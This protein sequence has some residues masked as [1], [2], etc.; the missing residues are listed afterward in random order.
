MQFDEFLIAL[1]A[2]ATELSEP[3]LR[4][5]LHLCATAIEEGSYSLAI[6]DRDIRSRLK[7]GGDS[8]DK[9]K[10]D[11]ERILRVEARPRQSTVYHIPSNWFPIA[12]NMFSTVCDP[13]NG[14]RPYL[15]AP[16]RAPVGGARVTPETGQRAPVG[17]AACPGRRGSVTPETGQRAPVG[18]AQT[19]ENSEKTMDMSIMDS[20]RSRSNS[21]SGLRKDS[22]ECI[23]RV[24]EAR[25]LSA[26]QLPEAIVLGAEMQSRIAALGNVAA[27]QNLPDDAVLAQCLATGTL[28]EIFPALAMAKTRGGRPKSYAW[29]VSVLLENLHGISRETTKAVRQELRAARMKKHTAS[30]SNLEFS[31]NL[32]TAAAAGVKSVH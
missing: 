7:M 8:L 19:V 16:S 2:Q 9:G 27:A 5:L 25:K 6:A 30:E 4:L 1:D 29:F 11:I 13:G 10:R 18:G 17:G 14:A 3:G 31:R 21:I 20:G 12:S 28:S 23:F 32:V 24:L 22:R 26:E 15:V